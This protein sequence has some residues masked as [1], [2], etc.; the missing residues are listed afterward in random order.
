M[1]FNQLLYEIQLFALSEALP[2]TSKHF[3]EVFKA[4]TPAFRACYIV[5]RTSHMLQPQSTLSR[6]LRY[7]ICSKEVLEVFRRQ[8]NPILDAGTT[9]ELPKRLF[10]SLA[11]K[12]GSV[13]GPSPKWIDREHPLPYLKYLYDTPGIPLPDVDSH[14]GYALTKAVHAGFIPLVCFLLARGASPKCKKG[15]AVMVAIRRKD[16]SLVRMLIERPKE[17]TKRRKLEDRILVNSEMLK[18]AVKCQAWDIVEYLT[19][20]KGCVPDMQTLRLM[21]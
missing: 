8:S 4:S 20:E 1:I 18:M 3:L 17:G 16:L 2:N 6:A 19:T 7:P 11:P 9:L 21:H 14:A 15:L 12:E 10:K 5:G 13:D